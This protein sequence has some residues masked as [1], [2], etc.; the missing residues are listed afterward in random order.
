G[1]FDAT[2]VALQLGFP[3]ADR[4]ARGT[5]A[6]ARAN[7]RQAEAERARI[8]KTI[9]AEVLDAIA[10]LE[11]AAQRIEAARSA[12]QAA[13]TQLSTEQDR[14]AGGSPTSFRVLPRQNDL[15]RARLDE[16]SALTDYRLARTELARATGS[17]PAEPRSLHTPTQEKSQ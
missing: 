3:L 8:R 15:S 4:A 10:S 2:R 17:L 12:R 5:A 14:F 7:E 1:D 11:T 16:I 9:H 6:A 13:E